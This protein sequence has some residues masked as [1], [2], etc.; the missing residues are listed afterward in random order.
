[1]N[2]HISLSEKIYLLGIHPKKGGIVAAAHNAMNFV[3]IGML[4]LELYL[5]KNVRFEEKR[6]VL[7]DR[8]S[9]NVLH[10]FLL[11]KIA[12]SKRELKIASW[13]NKFTF[14]MKFVRREVQNGLV[15][16]RIIR[17]EE[18]RF[19]FFR[20]TSPVIINFQTLYKLLS[21]V[22]SHIVKGTNNDEELMLLSF[23]KPSGL[24]PR[25]FPE[26]EKRKYILEKL[27]K[28]LDKNQV[29]TAV[30]NAF[31]AA[32]AVAASVAAVNAATSTVSA[33]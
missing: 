32:Q 22:E 12:K 20:W 14:S 9:S 2:D 13:I 8:K 19:L 31:V 11:D 6:V 30:A 1:M 29:S 7:A 18:K 24:L 25:I 15:S 16:K 5:N 33:S 21:E 27:N 23:L 28:V 10:Q 17:M 3:L 4:F 26:R